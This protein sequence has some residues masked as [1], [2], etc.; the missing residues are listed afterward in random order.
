MLL[1]RSLVLGAIAG[2]LVWQRSRLIVICR[3]MIE[4]EDYSGSV[5][6]LNKILELEAVPASRYKVDS[7]HDLVYMELEELTIYRA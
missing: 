5:R 4:L 3:S 1:Y 6:E 7:N 2:I